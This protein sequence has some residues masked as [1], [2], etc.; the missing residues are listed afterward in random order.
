MRK[1]ILLAAAAMMIPAAVSAQSTMDQ[2]SPAPTDT[3]S[4]MS[5][6]PQGADTTA[7]STMGNAAGSASDSAAPSTGAADAGMP[8]GDTTAGST[9]G[10]SAD[11]SASTDATSPS[12]AMNKSYPT[13]SRTV[14]DSCRNPGGK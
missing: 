5:T 4:T 2:T 9:A 10:T 3:S 12:A 1:T 6:Q 8:A 13:C 14:Q 7:Q 11:M